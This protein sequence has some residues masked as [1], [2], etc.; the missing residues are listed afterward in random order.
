MQAHSL[1]T[2]AAR[3]IRPVPPLPPSE[4]LIAEGPGLAHDAGNLLG[5][6]HLY[7]DLLGAPGV[8]RGDHRRYAAELRVLADRST[9]L[10][11]RL[12]SGAPTRECPAEGACPETDPVTSL[13]HLEPVL[14]RIAAPDASL[15]LDLSA[16][17]G[18]LPFPAEV[19]ERIVLNLVRNAATA[20]RYA[21]TP[22][23]N[24]HVSL[25][26]TA[27]RLVLA[28][29]DNGPGMAPQVAARFL[30]PASE[31][32]ATA[33]GMGHRIIHELAHSTGAGLSLRVRPGRGSC[34]EL[35]WP[36][37]CH[38]QVRDVVRGERVDA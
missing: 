18:P 35:S 22:A 6:L 7:C 1:S 20:L 21:Q 29:A 17:A 19:L 16:T 8:L 32:N 33:P 15:T 37:A 30:A 28:V 26:K 10:I 24:I 36:L 34:F 3:T 2:R 13:R 5:A 27:D 31:S 12:L 25:A 38:G 11:G 23:G 9:A 4:A 14:A